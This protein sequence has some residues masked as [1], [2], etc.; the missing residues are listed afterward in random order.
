MYKAVSS[1]RELI[2]VRHYVLYKYL[3]IPMHSML[4]LHAIFSYHVYHMNIKTVFLSGKLIEEI[5]TILPES[6]NGLG[7]DITV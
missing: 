4:A 7:I 3:P 1:Q 5:Y 6:R 2:I